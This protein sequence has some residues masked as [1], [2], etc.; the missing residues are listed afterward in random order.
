MAGLRYLSLCVL[1]ALLLCTVSAYA[2]STTVEPGQVFVA[3]EVVQ[4]GYILMFS[5][6]LDP[7]YLFTVSVK[8]RNTG[9]VLHWWRDEVSGAVSI[10]SSTTKQ[11]Y[12]AVFDNSN[13]V[14][15]SKY[16]NFELRAVQDPEH[17]VDKE[18]VDPIEV[19]IGT[20]MAKVHKMKSL[21]QTMRYQQSSHRAT[22][23]DANERVLLWSILQV[24]G[25]LAACGGQM[26]M[27]K[28]F[29]ERKR[30]I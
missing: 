4:P 19:K 7:D 10:P 15:T 2:V 14:L 28:L 25:F 17:D 8:D 18:L 21:Q 23:E 20:L 1:T 11:V 16:V 5:F 22:V 6:Q 29:L 27:L 13:S 24:V 3:E 26:Y 12:H 9:I 30:T